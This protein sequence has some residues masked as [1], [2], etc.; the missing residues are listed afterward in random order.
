MMEQHNES[1]KQIWVLIVE[2]DYGFFQLVSNFLTLSKDATFHMQN[3]ISIAEAKKA[4]AEANVDA[5][6]LDLN[7]ADSQGYNTFQKMQELAPHIPIIVLTGNNSKQLGMQA[8]AEG[9]QDFLQKQESAH[10]TLLPR[11]LLYAI[12]RHRLRQE[13]KEHYEAQLSRLYNEVN[14]LQGMFVDIVEEKPDLAERFP[15]E[16]SKLQMKYTQAWMEME[17]E[18][19]K[20]TVSKLLHEIAVSLG[21]MHATSSEVVNLHVA[22]LE[23][24]K[25]VLPQAK[26]ISMV[27]AGRLMLIELIGYLIEYYRHQLLNMMSPMPEL[28]N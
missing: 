28:T 27:L 16:C 20:Q 26:I 10:P 12:E 4:L 24:R 18:N 1:Q 15:E 19:R 17:I 21:E 14:R 25:D 22:V 11:V 7:I 23:E 13:Q 6:L 8:V 3:V 2:D 9:A 5:I